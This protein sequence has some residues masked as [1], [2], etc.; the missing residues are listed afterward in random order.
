MTGGKSSFLFDKYRQ[1]SKKEGICVLVVKPV[2]DTRTP[3]HISTYWGGRISARCV[4]K[5]CTLDV[6]QY[7]VIFLDEAHWFDDLFEFVASNM[8]HKNV[9]IFVCGLVGDK[10]QQKYGQI[11]DIIPLCSHIEW[12]PAICDKCGN[13]CAFSKCRVDTDQLDTPGGT[14]IYYTVCDQHLDM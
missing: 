7:D 13:D 5:L 2:K 10:H 9:R 11:C 1:Y 3:N 12:K 14:D 8:H 4:H 6:D